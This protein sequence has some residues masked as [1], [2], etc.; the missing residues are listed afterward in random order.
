MW[1][2][3]RAFTAGAQRLGTVVWTGDISVSWLALATTPSAVLNWVMA[4]APFVACDIG[5]FEGGATPPALLTRWYQL[6][7]F[8]PVMR[9]HS[10]I[11]VCATRMNPAGGRRCDVTVTRCAV[12]VTRCDV[13]AAR[14]HTRLS[15]GLSCART[16]ER[17]R[18]SVCCGRSFAC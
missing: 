9:V 3:N 6:G 13:A 4:G 11:Q 1:S 5:G 16:R 18:S 10:R 7:V 8:L 14:V 2:L 17:T 15:A 12:T